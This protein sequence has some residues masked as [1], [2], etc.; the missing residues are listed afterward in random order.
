MIFGLEAF[1]HGPRWAPQ[2]GHSLI[3]DV[4]AVPNNFSLYRYVKKIEERV[5]ILT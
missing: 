3:V 2:V 4:L 5:Y 1:T